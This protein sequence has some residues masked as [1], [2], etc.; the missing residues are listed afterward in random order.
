MYEMENESFQTK[1][2]QAKTKIMIYADGP[3]K[4]GK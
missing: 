2:F 4:C 3:E 1:L